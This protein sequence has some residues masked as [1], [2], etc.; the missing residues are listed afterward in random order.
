MIYTNILYSLTQYLAHN[1]YWYSCYHFALGVHKYLTINVFTWVLI[2][3]PN[4]FL[5][6]G[7][8]IEKGTH[9][10]QSCSGMNTQFFFVLQFPGSVDKV[11]CSSP[12]FSVHRVAVGGP[13]ISM[14]LCMAAFA[15]VP[16]P[17]CS[18]FIPSCRSP[19]ESLP[20]IPVLSVSCSC[21][22]LSMTVN[23]PPRWPWLSVPLLFSQA[24]ADWLTQVLP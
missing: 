15:G 18:R 13:Y 11:F 22:R 8:L 7:D 6:L 4:L 12:F 21:G 10:P 23:L 2:L 5:L 3:S 16:P 24:L 19:V 17:H 20:V 9:Y 14:A 1:T